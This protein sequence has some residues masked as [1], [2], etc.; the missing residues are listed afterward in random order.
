M[1]KRNLDEIRYLS[2]E[3]TNIEL[4]MVAYKT[5]L[6]KDDHGLLKTVIEELTK[7]ERNFILKKDETT[8]EVQKYKV[9]TQGQ[10]QVIDKLVAMVKTK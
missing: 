10:T 5:A 4:K 7:T 9:E 6:Y 2:N 3:R 1:Y 8:V